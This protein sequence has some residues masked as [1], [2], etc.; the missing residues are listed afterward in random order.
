MNGSL[1]LSLPSYDPPCSCIHH[2]QHRHRF[3]HHRRLAWLIR[4]MGG[5]ADPTNMYINQR[6]E[7]KK[8]SI[9]P[10][11]LACCS[12]EFPLH[13]AREKWTCRFQ[14]A[15]LVWR[16]P[17]RLN[18]QYMF[19]ES[20][21]LFLCSSLFEVLS[22]YMSGSSFTFQVEAH[23]TLGTPTSSFAHPVRAV[24]MVRLRL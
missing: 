11:R 2:L 19:R 20:L 1:P 9:D 22:S 13:V 23:L 21:G 15:F 3:Y 10:L 7:R 17:N 12:T 24:H 8:Y 6:Y 18:L 14:P 4:I 16:L 5:G